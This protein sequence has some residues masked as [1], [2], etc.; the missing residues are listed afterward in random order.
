MLCRCRYRWRDFTR[1]AYA[2]AGSEQSGM[3]ALDTLRANGDGEIIP[4]RVTLNKEYANPHPHHASPCLIMPL[5]AS[6]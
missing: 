2:L 6:S 1:T 4:S 5:H 3:S